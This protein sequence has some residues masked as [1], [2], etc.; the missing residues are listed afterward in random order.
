MDR[1]FSADEWMKMTVTER[2]VRCS[3]LARE[4]QTLAANASPTMSGH[5]LE[6]AAQW[7]KLAAEIERDAIQNSKA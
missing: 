2:I 7:T 4:A 3:I 6:I 5:Y 1:R